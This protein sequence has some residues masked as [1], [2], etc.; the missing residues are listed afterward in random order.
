[1]KVV[2][3]GNPGVGANQTLSSVLEIGATYNFRGVM[4]LGNTADMGRLG[5]SSGLS[6]SY[7]VA[8]TPNV[9]VNLVATGVSVAIACLIASSGA[10]GA[11]GNFAYFDSISLRKVL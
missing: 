9:N 7:Q 8:S 11:A 10:W 4:T 5:L 2:S 6:G 3:D 1:M